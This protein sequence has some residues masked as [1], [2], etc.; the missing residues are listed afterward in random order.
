MLS[1]I[2]K[3]SKVEAMFMFLECYMHPLDGVVKIANEVAAQDGGFKFEK[4]KLGSSR[5][6]P[7][8][9]LLMQKK[10]IS[11]T[12]FDAF[13]TNN[14]ADDSGSHDSSDKNNGRSSSGN[15]SKN[16]NP[17]P[18][19][20]DNSGTPDAQGSSS[21]DGGCSGGGGQTVNTGNQVGNARPEIKTA[22]EDL[23]AVSLGCASQ[24]VVNQMSAEKSSTVPQLAVLREEK[25]W[26]YDTGE[27]QFVP[28]LRPIFDIANTTDGSCCDGVNDRVEG[29]PMTEASDECHDLGSLHLCAPPTGPPLCPTLH[30]VRVVV[31]LHRHITSSPPSLLLQCCIIFVNT[32]HESHCPPSP[33]FGKSP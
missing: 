15:D 18:S 12:G 16:G 9:C 27:Y 14:A 29:S 13:A 2:F 21:G 24:P 7:F 25:T 6:Y 5:E 11:A 17:S 1:L 33:G 23:S 28:L 31:L 26:E 4:A 3:E 20:P 30:D 10:S 19:S 8:Y 22:V 32:C